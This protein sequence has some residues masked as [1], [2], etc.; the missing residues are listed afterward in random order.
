MACTVAQDGRTSSL[1]A[2]NGIAQVILIS[3]T[4]HAATVEVDHIGAIQLHGTGTILGDP[5]EVSSTFKAL[6]PPLKVSHAPLMAQAV[7]SRSGHAEPASGCA[8]FAHLVH[9]LSESAAI[10]IVHLRHLNAHVSDVLSL[11]SKIQLALFTRENMQSLSRTQAMSSFA[12]QGTNAH[13]IVSVAHDEFQIRRQLACK[14]IMYTPIDCWGLQIMAPFRAHVTNRVLETV[15]LLNH[16]EN[17]FLTD[18]QV[19]NRTCLPGTLLAQ[20]LRESMKN[21]TKNQTLLLLR[22]VVF[23]KPAHFGHVQIKIWQRTGILSNAGS[24]I[25]CTF[26]FALTSLTHT[27]QRVHTYTKKHCE[28]QSKILGRVDSQHRPSPF[29]MS[30]TCD[31]CLQI[32]QT[33]S[34]T[35]G[36]LPKAVESIRQ[37]CMASHSMDVMDSKC[38]MQTASAGEVHASFILYSAGNKTSP[39][40]AVCIMHLESITSILCDAM[41]FCLIDSTAFGRYPAVIE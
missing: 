3:T 30:A 21:I 40:D 8:S 27:Q 4:A 12:F 29:T 41:Q 1:T 16:V 5:I 18:H 9:S 6:R 28:K 10:A 7:K 34:I 25:N 39:A 33:Y 35:A 13:A 23:I 37:N 31:A 36:Y 11:N 32:C 38:M 26:S 24:A 22:D 14:S 17:Q 2:P 15:F 20:I 19:L